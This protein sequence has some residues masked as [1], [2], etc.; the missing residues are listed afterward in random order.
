MF[1]ALAE[2]AVARGQLVGP[3]LQFAE[4]PGVLQRDDRLVGEGADQFDLT[5]GEWL[6]PLAHRGDDPHRFALP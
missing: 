3:L 2:F 5:F 6:D 4:Q 1:D